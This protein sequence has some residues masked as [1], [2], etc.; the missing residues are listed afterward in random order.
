MRHKDANDYLK[1]REDAKT[2]AQDYYWN[3]S[4]VE[5]FGIIGSGSLFEYG[6]EAANDEGIDIPFH[7]A[8]LKPY[9]PKF[10]FDSIVLIVGST[11]IGKT[12]NLDTT[13]TSI[14]MSTHE[15]VMADGRLKRIEDIKKDDYVMGVDSK[16][17]S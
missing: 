17:V 12:A 14:I 13:M 8:D 2:F 10:L 6:L 4:P 3:V 9:I 15:I 11:S 1:N 5:D 7:M 16:Q